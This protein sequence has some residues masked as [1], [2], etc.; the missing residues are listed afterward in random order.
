MSKIKIIQTRSVIGQTKAQRS[1][2]SSLKLGRIG[3]VAEHNDTPDIRGMLRK[4]SHLIQIH[5]GE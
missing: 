5:K 4:V 3:K 1:T 2:L